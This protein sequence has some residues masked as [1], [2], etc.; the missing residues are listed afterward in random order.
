MKN[1]KCGE[2]GP[3]KMEMTSFI[4]KMVINFLG[5]AFGINDHN[6]FYHKILN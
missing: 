6:N 1:I 3:C 4:S 5:Q 2:Y